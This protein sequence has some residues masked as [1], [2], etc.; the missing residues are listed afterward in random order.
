MDDQWPH[1]QYSTLRYWTVDRW[2]VPRKLF[3]MNVTQDTANMSA[4]QDPQRT[5]VCVGVVEVN[6]KSQY[7]AKGACWCVCIGDAVF[8]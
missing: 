6:T 2:N 3:D 4:R 8:Y 1:R 7:L 5:I